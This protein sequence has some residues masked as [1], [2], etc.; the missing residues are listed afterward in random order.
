MKRLMQ[1]FSLMLIAV[2]TLTACGSDDKG[3]VTGP[4]DPTIVSLQVT[5]AVV[6]SP[7]GLS[8]QYKA[9]AKMSDNSVIDVTTDKILSWSSSDSN[10]V[11]IDT[12]TGIATGVAV[13]TVT[14]TASGNANGA[15]FSA[16][17]KLTVTDATVTSLQVTPLDATVVA[18]LEQAFTAQALMSDSSVL[19]VTTDSALSWSSSDSNIATIDTDTGIATGVAVGTVTITASGS[20]NGTEFTASAELT[21]T[22]ATVTSLQITPQDT[23]V[24]AGL[25]QAFT[26]QALMSDSSVLDVTT[27][28]ALSWSSNDTN[29]ATIDTDTGIATGVAVGTVTITAS[30]NAN[31]AEFTASAELT[32]T[33]ATVTSLQITPLDATVVAGLEQALTAQALLSDSSVLDVTTNAALSWSS[34]DSNIATIDTDTGIA[35]GVA[36]GTVTITASGNANGAE[37]SASAKLTVTDAT[38]TSLQVTP[39]DATVVAGLEQAFTAQA[40]MSDSSVL[41]VTTDSALSWSSSNSNIATIDTDTGI[42]TGVAVGTVTITASGSA[43][44]AEFTASAELRVTDATVT[45]LQ[46]TPLDASVA[47]GLEQAFTAQALMSDSSVLD[48]TTDSVLSWSSSDSNIATIDTDTGIATGVA[49]GTVIITASGSA[50]GTE[51]TASA[52]LT[53]TDATVTSLQVTPFD[54]SV[55]AGL[56]QAFT[57]QALLSD[58]SVLDVTTNAALSWSSSDNNIATI[59]TDT[60]IATGVTVG[61]VTITASGNAN[62]AEF[63]AS[64]EL[65]V[66]PAAVT[67]IEV[68]PKVGK[69]PE[70]KTLAYTATALFSDGSTL[71]VT[72]ETL[73]SWSSSNTAA[74]TIDNDSG[75]VTG[76]AIGTTDITALAVFESN[77]FKDTVPLSVIEFIPYH[78]PLLASETHFDESVDSKEYIVYTDEFGNQVTGPT[79]YGYAAL[80]VE[81]AIDECKRRGK[82]LVSS[83]NQ[84]N[85]YMNEHHAEA[86]TWPLVRFFWTS[87]L[88]TDEVG[89]WFNYRLAIGELV[90]PGGFEIRG[91]D[92]DSLAFV[93]CEN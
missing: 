23:T 52:E 59:D 20:A 13:G 11:T 84:F 74:A 58:S 83:A 1:F 67:A 8:L 80:K 68:T 45:S 73:V 62:G 86:S 72:A 10:I 39:L 53:V 60:G 6:Q 37:F 48:V 90:E 5:P 69:V 3:L 2:L 65:T 17:A 21:V 93:V 29:I 87:E 41:D 70:G 66:A 57:A 4:N 18:G 7:A 91:Q 89:S 79:E 56:E 47:A 78:R 88:D 55:V 15:E 92:P 63:T 82:Q 9:L 34:S 71:D 40:L 38:V 43:N 36:V 81:T 50:N 51:F 32:V 76:E 33:N 35:T 31:G 16:S 27:D 14:I 61:T 24:V 54:A 22:N 30:G 77:T 26:A 64:A 46:V 75:V 12:D 49:A 19:D 42:A 44:G 28:S 25:E 85:D